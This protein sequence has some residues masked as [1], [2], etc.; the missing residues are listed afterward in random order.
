MLCNLH[1]FQTNNAVSDSDVKFTCHECG[2]D[3]AIATP[4]C[5]DVKFT[6]HE[7]GQDQAI[8]TPCCIDTDSHE[9]FAV[10]LHEVHISCNAC[11]FDMTKLPC[12]KQYQPTMRL[13]NN[14]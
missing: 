10:N 14:L 2:Q 7:C 5:S 11:H 13:D 9:R 1:F 12:C 6:C 4:C 8:A 3:Q